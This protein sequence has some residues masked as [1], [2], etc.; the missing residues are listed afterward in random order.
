[1]VDLRRVIAHYAITGLFEETSDDSRVYAYRV[2]R[3]DEAREAYDATALR[4]AHV[5]VRSEI[6]GD[7]REAMYAVLHFGGH[8]FSC[9]VRGWEDLPTYEAMKAD[10]LR[11]YGRLSLTDM[12]RGLDEYFPRELYSLPHLFLE[13]RRRV[14]ARVLEAVLQKHEQTYA[15]IWEETR[16]VIRYLRGAEALIP[17]VLAITARH[18][19][20]RDITTELGRMASRGVI[21]DHVLGLVDE[22]RSLGLAVDLAAAR[23]AMRDA[24]RLLLDALAAAPLP[25]TVAEAVTLVQGAERLQVGFGRWA[26]QNQFFDLWRAHPEAHGVLVP[27][28]TALGFDLTAEHRA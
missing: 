23:P 10:L 24:V 20:E 25:E 22:A 13:E 1:V 16:K 9:G 11:R 18:V 5:R 26:A 3:L 21:S 6:T 12:V 19:L 2:E 7:A 27:L 8:D 28:A 15:R 17:D 14:L 4:V